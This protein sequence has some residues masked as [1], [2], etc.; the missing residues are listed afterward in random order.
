LNIKE[1]H[2]KTATVKGLVNVWKK[3]G[4]NAVKIYLDTTYIF[5]NNLETWISKIK[6]LIDE[7]KYAS[8]NEEIKLIYINLNLKNK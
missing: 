7:K 3:G 5:D 8:V 1:E 2:I 6:K 4:I